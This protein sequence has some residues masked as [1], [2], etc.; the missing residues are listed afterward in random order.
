MLC[1]GYEV[2]A[3]VLRCTTMQLAIMYGVGALGVLRTRHAHHKLLPIVCTRD[4]R[5]LRTAYNLANRG[6]GLLESFE[7]LFTGPHSEQLH[8][9]H[10]FVSRIARKPSLH[11]FCA[12]PLCAPSFHR[13]FHHHLV[14]V[15]SALSSS[16]SHH[17]HSIHIEGYTSM[18]RSCDRSCSDSDSDK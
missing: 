4:L 17:I 3:W 9:P 6:N 11:L 18:F 12:E 2:R 16:V 13:K 8:A 10:S 1:R 7:Q 14:D 5:V 15:L